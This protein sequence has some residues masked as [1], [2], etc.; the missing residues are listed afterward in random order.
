MA[1]KRLDLSGQKFG[2]LVAIKPAPNAKNRTR[3]YCQCECGKEIIV[4]TADLKRGH[5]QSC[6]CYKAQRTS[7]SSLIDHTGKCFGYLEVLERDMNYQGKGVTTHWICK[8]HKC[9]NI[10]SISS[11]SLRNGA[12]SCGCV[13]S[14]GEYKIMMLLQQYSIN[15]ITEFK[16]EDYKNRRYDFALLNKEG[17]VVRLIEF[18]GL[19]HYY[20]PRAEHWASASS[21]EETQQRDQEKNA[22][23]KSKGIGLV[24]IPYWHLDKL[25]IIDLLSDK[26]LI[27]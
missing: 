10:K 24:R 22:I 20:K 26:F 27:K 7:E 25:T 8:C 12:I 11:D 3:W 23:A 18:D 16:F 15:Y 1:G 6:G 4:D 2:K 9:G 14:R 17:Q 21:L 5:T 19:Q 13:K